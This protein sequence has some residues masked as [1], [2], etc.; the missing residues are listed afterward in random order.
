MSE[1]GKERLS[2][3]GLDCRIGTKKSQQETN[4]VTHL[5]ALSL[6]FLVVSSLIV[7]EATFPSMIQVFLYNDMK[8]L[9]K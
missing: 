9:K 8:V 3:V 2:L 1:S 6:F 5:L 4:Y 7:L